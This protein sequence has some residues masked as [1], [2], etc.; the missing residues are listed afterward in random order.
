[1]VPNRK[2]RVLLLDGGDR[3]A[4]PVSKALRQAGRCVTVLCEHRISFGAW[5]RWPHYR[6]FGPSCQNQPQAYL[7]NLLRL[8]KRRPQDV[9]IPL[10]DHTATLASRHQ[11]LLSE[12][13][14]LPLPD[15]DTFML[16]RDK[17]RTMRACAAAGVPHPITADPQEESLDSISAR[18]GF[19]C[20]VK[21][22]IGHGAIGIR[23]AQERGELEGLCRQVSRTFGPCCVQEFIPQTGMQHKA[24]LFRGRDGR[25]HAAVV[26]NKPRYF[27]PSGG[28]SS[29]NCTVSRPDIVADCTRLLE[30][31][32]WTGH[33]DVDLIDDPRDGK[34]KVM[35]INPRI[36]GS[37][38]IAFE[39]GVDFA[40][41]SVRH[42]LG[43]PLPTYRGY[44]V[45]VAMR[46]MPLD[47][48]WFVH[49]PDRWKARPSWFKF[50]GTDLCYQEGSADDPLPIVAGFLA[51]LRKYLSPRFRRGKLGR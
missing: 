16:A 20:I 25:I 48:L 50:W 47:I 1:M 6:E 42:A 24:Q 29:L 41:L 19:P 45:G 44:R 18:V 38:K 3:Q 4:L 36:T 37:I 12:Y 23:R 39:A 30:A 49:S 43:Q 11:E 22:N 32:D 46:Y 9:T 8:L 5:S 51:G 21:P 10:F 15:H 35:E 34:A 17:R 13:T 40:D 27:P 14:R 2:I 26:F 31:M 33:A 7:E 28:T